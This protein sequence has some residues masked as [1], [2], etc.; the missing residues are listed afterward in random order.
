MAARNLPATPVSK[1]SLDP[2]SVILNALTFGLFITSVKGVGDARALPAAIAELAAAAAIGAAFV[3]RQLR[4]AM[5]LLPLDLLKRPVFALSLATSIS[6]FAAQSLALVA[7]PFY[8]EETLIGPSTAARRPSEAA[9]PP[10][11]SRRAL[12]RSV[13]R[14]SLMAVAFGRSPEHAISIALWTAAGLSLAG[15]CATGFRRA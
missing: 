9:A 4:R 13:F 12:D 3:R 6:S 14:R 8:F 11:C 7:L 10:D 15:A 1:C 5:P 2:V